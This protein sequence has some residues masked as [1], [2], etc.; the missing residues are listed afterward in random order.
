MRPRKSSYVVSLLTLLF[1]SLPVQAGP[2]TCINS[3]R[4]SFSIFFNRFNIE[5]LLE[6]Y[7]YLLGDDFRK[8]LASLNTPEH[9]WID[10]GAGLGYATGEYVKSEEGSRTHVTAI[11]RYV[12]LLK[13]EYL[14]GIGWF[15]IKYIR[16]IESETQGRLRF[17]SGKPFE[18]IS[19]AEIGK[20]DLIT[21]LLGTF[22]Y[23]E[24]PSTVLQKY[25]DLLKP[26]GELYLYLG[27]GSRSTVSDPS[28]LN[29]YSF[30]SQWLTN[31]QGINAEVTSNG[32]VR[33][34]KTTMEVKVPQLKMLHTTADSPPIRKYAP[35]P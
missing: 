17:L 26:D 31:I 33:I 18:K 30:I 11:S 15:P 3:L 20:A 25:L 6:H 4:V 16:K 5:R 9:H 1:L 2:I 22:S 34:T 29:G 7:K 32:T 13:R 35:V 8:K 28:N 10:S 21:D 23:S 14:G 24:D 12:P 27:N 19:N